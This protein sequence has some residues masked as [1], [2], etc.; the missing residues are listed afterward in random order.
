MV[1]TTTTKSN[2]LLLFTLLISTL[3][4]EYVLDNNKNV[5]IISLSSTCHE[6]RI[7]LFNGSAWGTL[8]DCT[9]SFRDT[10]SICKTL[11]WAYDI[12]KWIGASNYNANNEYTANISMNPLTAYTVL[13][14]CSDL[15][16]DTCSDCTLTRNMDICDDAVHIHNAFDV[17]IRCGSYNHDIN[18]Q[19]E[20]IPFDSNDNLS[21]DS[22]RYIA[23]DSQRSSASDDNRTAVTLL[24]VAIL[25][26]MLVVIVYAVYSKC[27]ETKRLS[28][29]QGTRRKSNYRNYGRKSGF[30]TVPQG[31]L[32]LQM[33]AIRNATEYI[34]QPQAMFIYQT[35]DSHRDDDGHHRDRDDGRE[36]LNGHNG[37]YNGFDDEQEDEDNL[38][39]DHSP[40][41]V[42]G[43]Y[44]MEEIIPSV[45]YSSNNNSESYG[46]IKNQD[47]DEEETLDVRDREDTT[48]TRPEVDDTPDID[49]L[50]TP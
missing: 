2:N 36:A 37:R 29:L 19:Y 45:I 28:L 35:R 12:E 25:G 14:N 41:A 8:S 27:Q 3:S 17:F 10:E 50:D 1:T 16:Y 44:D 46:L 34:P 22:S 38:T 47:E 32:E 9:H 13:T 4:S 24:A 11:G 42:G 21:Y 18:D 7:E 40:G 49:V 33:G 20:C 6:G 26:S 5:R 48:D 39:V 43:G 15:P 31:S 30:A 23:C